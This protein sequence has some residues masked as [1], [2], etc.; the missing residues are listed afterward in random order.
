M[1]EAVLDASALLAL[2]NAEPG[3]D[4]VVAALPTSV[5][6]AVNFSEVV[7]TLM[8]EGMPEAGI[9]EAMQGLPLEIV[10]FDIEQAYAAGALRPT[11]RS[12]GLS[13]GDRGCLS[14][15]R[16]LGIPALITDR[17]WGQLDVGVEV[18]VIR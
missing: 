1:T 2:L 16:M 15:A 9:K 11:T 6:S 7:A 5:I 10:P 4:I 13:L 8:V 17:A 18:R 12:L 3:A 14:L